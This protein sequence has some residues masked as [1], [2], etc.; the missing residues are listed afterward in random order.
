MVP[1]E[2]MSTPGT[3]VTSIMVTSK[4]VDLTNC[5]REQIQY[6]GAIQPHGA[7]LVLQEPELRILQASRNT[8]ELL[9]IAAANLVGGNLGTLFTDEQ[10]ETMRGRFLREKL[11]SAPAHIARL[12]F[13]GREFDVLAH[14]CDRVLILELEVRP[15]TTGASVLDLYSD[16]RGAISRLEATTSLQSFLDLAALQVRHFTGFDR[17]MIYKFMED[18]SG[19]VRSEALSDGIEPYLGLHYPP[20]DIPAPARRLFSLTWVRHQP[21]ISYA[22]VPVFPE[23]NP[24]TGNPL[25]MSY[26]LLRSVSIMYVDYL[27]NM[28][29]RSSLVMTLLKEGNLWGLIA[30]HHHTGPKHVQYEVRVACEFLAHMVSLLMSAK[31]DIENHEYRVKLKSTQALMVENISRHAD[32]V[33]GFVEDSPNLLQFIEAGGAATS[34]NGKLTTIG[35]T[36]SQ[37]EIGQIVKWLSTEIQEDVFATDCLSLRFPPAEAFKDHCAGLL[38]LRFSNAKDDFL[39]WFRPEIVR[40]VKW[41]G[42]PH[43]PVDISGDGRL[44][45][46]TSFAL[47]KETVRLKSAPWTH[48]EVQAARELRAALLELVLNRA[49]EL[50]RLY[51]DLERSHAELDSFAYVASHDL[52]EPLRGIHN[53]AEMLRA[54]YADKLDEQGA[55]KLATLGRLSQRMD[56]LLDALLEYSRVGREEFSLTRV[57]LN[58]VVGD[59]L[60]LLDARIEAANVTIQI[61]RPLPACSGDHIRLVEVFTNL[62]SNAIKYNDKPVKEVEIGFEET[63]SGGQPVIYVR[64][65]GIGIKEKHYAQIF[66]IFRRLH[67]HDG[68]G[69]GSGAGLTITAKIIERIGGRIWLKSVPGDGTTFYFTVGK[70][71]PFEGAH[72]PDRP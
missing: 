40:T 35:G 36:P 34:V 11:D 26:A 67:P 37:A 5:D 2:I 41:A 72:E 70:E 18:G 57:D 49:E 43:K 33:S 16:L 4:T 48:V 38:A 15:E 25:D 21:D 47:W 44:H 6:V 54:D 13:A 39:L 1:G 32:F 9:G 69:G 68:F 71:T 52:K 58:R 60:E 59:A 10:L 28:G 3:G 42:D 62:I 65:N 8:A 27:K 53:Y 45:P 46:R 7:M 63:P 66:Q 19:W 31:E 55:A 51:A 17:V 24:L 12:K 29:T 22:P 30:C 64:D 50:G 20:S 23:V 61:P 14:R 56:Q